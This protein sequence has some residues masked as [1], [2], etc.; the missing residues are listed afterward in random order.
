[1]I[2]LA[3]LHAVD[4]RA[5]AACD[6]LLCDI[7]M[8]DGGWEI[9]KNGLRGVLVGRL[10][11]LLAGNEDDRH[12]FAQ[13]AMAN[14]SGSSKDWTT[15]QCRATLQWLD[16]G[17]DQL[18]RQIVAAAVVAVARQR[19]TDP[20]QSS[21]TD[22]N[23]RRNE[24]MNKI[25]TIRVTY[26]GT[27]NLG[28]YNSVRASCEVE[29]DVAKGENPDDVA[30]GLWEYAQGQVRQATIKA[31]QAARAE[32]ATSAPTPPS[33]PGNVEPPPPPTSAPPAPPSAP[34]VPPP[35]GGGNVE[36]IDFM[37]ITAPKG[38]PVVE[39]W[40]DGR[41]YREVWWNLGGE[42]LLKIS[43][44]LAQAGFTAAHLDN[45]GQEYRRKLRVHWE[46]S[47]KNPKWKDITL[48]EVVA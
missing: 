30:A 17:G 41:S 13:V 36:D 8:Y 4:E 16:D 37:R 24:A 34:P 18:V 42:A 38:S 21:G 12:L 45:V 27:Y 48:V 10:N 47:P 35:P 46:Q 26:G 22:N 32:Q 2:T 3:E 14:P 44:A 43:P 5:A 29:A 1:V 19:E 25:K 20:A 7:D 39:F 23:E 9:A 6:A 40:R 11:K 28:D 33:H 31:V 15:A